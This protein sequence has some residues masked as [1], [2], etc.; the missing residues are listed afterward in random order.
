MIKQKPE[1]IKGRSTL[2]EDT[3]MKCLREQSSEKTPAAFTPS[4]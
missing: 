1:Q 3:I 4:A 2:E